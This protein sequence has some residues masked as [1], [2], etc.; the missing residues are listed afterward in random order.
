MVYIFFKSLKNDNL[1]K[2]STALL[3][4]PTPTPSFHLFF[5]N[6]IYWQLRGKQMKFNSVR[7]YNTDIY[8]TIKTLAK[9]EP[10]R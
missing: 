7:I 1:E 10:K 9:S 5:Y 3:K 6:L 2:L 4:R 8:K